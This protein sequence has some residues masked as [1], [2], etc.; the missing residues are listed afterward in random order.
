[1][2]IGSEQVKGYIFTPHSKHG[3]KKSSEAPLKWFQENYFVS[4]NSIGLIL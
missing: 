1:M 4:N 3:G 2:D